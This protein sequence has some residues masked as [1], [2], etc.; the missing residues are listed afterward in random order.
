MNPT[1]PLLIAHP[2]YQL[3]A[4]FRQISDIPFDEV[5]SIAA[6]EE[7]L[8]GV[9][10]LVVSRFWRSD[11]VERAPNLRFVQSISAG[12]DQFDKELLRAR[13][14]RL[15]SAQGVNERAV[16]EHAI[17]LMLALTRQLHLARDR[18]HARQWRSFITDPT[19][20]ELEVNG[21]SMLIIGMGRIGGRIASIGHA[22]GMEVVGVRRNPT[23]PDDAGHRI[24][25]L[26]QLGEVLP[27]ADV[28]VLTCPYTPETHELIG[29]RELAAMKREAF[30]VN[31]ARGK[32]V[33]ENA[34][35]AS[36]DNGRIAGAGLDCFVD[37]PLP[38]N[39][40]LWSMPN[41]VI[42]PHS[43][44]ETRRYEAGVMAILAENL[45]RLSRGEVL[46]N[47]IC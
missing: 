16:G 38:D 42:T 22:L 40:P 13:G 15:A 34:L 5:R 18:Q 45:A 37:E 12:T 36:L 32:V 6:V 23:G 41:V 47:Q 4:A 25:P 46:Q 11:F 35:I 9:E 19:S 29:A 10:T 28:V 1:R 20:R 21:M 33:D 17:G 43:A 31:V 26:A 44:G 8:A 24:V 39:S 2:A 7:R 14:I 27:Q 3:G 30:L